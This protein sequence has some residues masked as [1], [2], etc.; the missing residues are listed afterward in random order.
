[1]ING[2]RSVWKLALPCLLASIPPAQAA[3]PTAHTVQFVAVEKDVRL[4][5]LDW[6]GSGSRYPAK[7][8]GWTWSSCKRTCHEPGK[9]PNDTRQVIRRLLEQ[10]LP[11]VQ[12]VR[13][14]CSMAIPLRCRLL[15]RLSSRADRNTRLFR[16]P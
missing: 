3:D 5:V 13:R 10:Q 1:M 11:G 8:A 12:R 7:V 2:W 14:Q 16:F 9:R 6:G 15:L 4:E